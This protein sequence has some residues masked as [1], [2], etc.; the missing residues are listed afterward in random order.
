MPEDRLPWGGVTE[1]PD[2]A[3]VH[4]AVLNER[5]MRGGIRY[6]VFIRRAVDADGISISNPEAC[7]P[8]ELCATFNRR[9]GVLTLEAG[10]IRALGLDLRLDTEPDYKTACDH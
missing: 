7:S 5:W 8:S 10:S 9:F 3:S 1:L 6:N 2:N 4:R